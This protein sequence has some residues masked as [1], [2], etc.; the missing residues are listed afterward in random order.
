M[1]YQVWS[2]QGKKICC[3]S[4]QTSKKYL[5]KDPDCNQPSLWVDELEEIVLNDIFQLSLKQKE[6]KSDNR[7]SDSAVERLEE[8]IK[9]KTA[10]LS[11]LYDL[12]AESGNEVLLKKIEER[13]FQ[14]DSLKE[15]KLI[16]QQ[17]EAKTLIKR[18][19]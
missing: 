1:H 10:E 19:R 8:Q 9:I 12:Y 13:E 16:Q 17:Q 15:E 18:S 6:K 11:R 14:M 5:I 4:Q 2:K 3:Y 7:F